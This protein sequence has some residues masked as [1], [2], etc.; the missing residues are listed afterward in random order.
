MITATTSL[1]SYVHAYV[2]SGAPVGACDRM[3]L[4]VFGYLGPVCAASL[5]QEP[6]R[7]RSVLG[8]SQGSPF[9]R[10]RRQCP[11]SVSVRCK[12]YVSYCSFTRRLFLPWFEPGQPAHASSVR[13][14][15]TRSSRRD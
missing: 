3:C 7:L 6:S 11:R 2:I 10:R 1:V 5:H 4:C 15:E 9:A 14:L 13:K 12:T 8:Q